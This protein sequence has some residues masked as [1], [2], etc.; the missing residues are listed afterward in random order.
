MTMVLIN[1]DE[2]LVFKINNKGL[3]PRVVNNGTMG[4]KITQITL[5]WP[6]IYI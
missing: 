4:F 5:R 3:G 2:R 6:N 1:T